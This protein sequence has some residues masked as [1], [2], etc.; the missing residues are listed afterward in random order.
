MAPLVTSPPSST[1]G[2]QDNFDDE[3]LAHAPPPPILYSKYKQTPEAALPMS[4]ASPRPAPLPPT[5]PSTTASSS[6]S[7]SSST[8]SM[9]QLLPPP[10]LSPPIPGSNLFFF[11][12]RTPMQLITLSNIKLNNDI[13]SAQ[14]LSIH[15]RVLVK[16]FL[17]LLYDSNPMF[18]YWFDDDAYQEGVGVGSGEG[19]P[20]GQC[21]IGH[22]GLVPEPLLGEDEQNGWIEQTLNAAG[23]NDD[24]DDDMDGSH[25]HHQKTKD[26]QTTGGSNNSHGASIKKASYSSSQPRLSSASPPLSAQA[27]TSDKARTP[28]LLP[29]KSSPPSSPHSFISFPTPIPRAPRSSSSPNTPSRLSLSTSRPKS[30]ELPQFLNSY[31][32]AVFDVDWSVGLPSTEDSLCIQSSLSSSPPVS[33]LSS[34]SSPKRISDSSASVS[35]FSSRSSTASLSSSMTSIESGPQ[36]SVEELPSKGK[37]WDENGS[38]LIPLLAKPAPSSDA[39]TSSSKNSHICK[40]ILVKKNQP[41]ANNA[42]SEAASGKGLHNKGEGSK[43]SLPSL[44][45]P[46]LKQNTKPKEN[47][48]P[49]RRSSLMQTG[50]VLGVSSPNTKKCSQEAASSTNL[51]ATPAKEVTASTISALSFPAVPSTTLFLA[52]DTLESASDTSQSS[53]TFA[54]RTSSLASERTG[55][56][57]QKALSSDNLVAPSNGLPQPLGSS[58]S[59]ASAILAA[60]SSGRTTAIAL[61]NFPSIPTGPP[62]MSCAV[63]S[64]GTLGGGTAKAGWTPSNEKKQPQEQYPRKMTYN[65]YVI[66][67]APIVIPAAPSLPY[68]EPA[69]FPPSSSRSP[70]QAPRQLAIGSSSGNV[71]PTNQLPSSSS[72]A[73]RSQSPLLRSPSRSQHSPTSA[74]TLPPLCPFPPKQVQ[75]FGSGSYTSSPISLDGY[76]QEQDQKSQPYLLPPHTFMRSVSDDEI[77]SRAYNTSSSTLS[78]LVNTRPAATY[79]IKTSRSSPDLMSSSEDLGFNNSGGPPPMPN[80]PQHHQH[81]HQKGHIYQYPSSVS[82]ATSLQKPGTMFFSAPLPQIPNFKGQ[83]S[84]YSHE[85]HRKVHHH[86]RGY[87]SNGSPSSIASTK[88]NSIKS[89]LGLKTST[90]K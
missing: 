54:R 29:P 83:T 44:P 65:S 41:K 75:S 25:R 32:S 53:P 55:Y 79:S 88:W 15:R 30:T 42:T 58:S 82:R 81:Q 59:P 50:Q 2:L 22:E 49:G 89:M 51:T 46:T 67:T 37:L 1:R 40:S 48:V 64:D 17:T 78:P 3:E 16:N 12:S 20:N 19:A 74:P 28:P 38:I 8:T 11:G 39:N 36:K 87:S 43:K 76:R 35:S 57:H 66:H 72:P 24:D 27:Q 45:A 61:S 86:R 56:Q 80:T 6:S 4:L 60:S 73:S 31:L 21:A 23:L 68:P 13:Y 52:G 71:H 84:S 33:S 90:R 63:T 34:L 14:S 77:Q 18:E 85:E 9:A 62:P 69:G 26:E 10:P 7:S 47:L 70:P 5:P